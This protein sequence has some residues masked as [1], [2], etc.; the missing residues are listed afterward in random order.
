MNLPNH[1]TCALSI[2]KTLKERENKAISREEIAKNLKKKKKHFS[3]YILSSAFRELLQNDVLVRRGKKYWINTLQIEPSKRKLET[4]NEKS[5]EINAVKKI[6]EK[7]KILSRKEINNLLPMYTI[8][9]IDQIILTLQEQGFLAKLQGDKTRG[10]YIVVSR[11]DKGGMRGSDEF[12]TDP[13]NAIV[14]VSGKTVIFCYHTAFEIHGLS[15]YGMSFV[16]YIHGRVSQDLSVLGNV[17]IKSVKLRSPGTGIM[18]YNRAGQNIRLTDVERTIIDCVHRPKYTVGWENVLYGL[19][20]VEQ[21]DGERILE[22]LKEFRTPSLN[23]KM[24]VILEHFQEKWKIERTLLNNIKLYCPS[25]PVRFFRNEPGK[26]NKQ[27]NIYV[28]E[29]MFE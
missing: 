21:L 7:H 1:I 11:E 2:L 17:Q 24:G 6:L 9:Q 20:K 28:P 14:S 25:T 12:I 10:K 29:G 22:F 15:R 18:S 8:V 4:F 19:K 26:F 27:W 3:N 23:A 13:V 5:I 16:I